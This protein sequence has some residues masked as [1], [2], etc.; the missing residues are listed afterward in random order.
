[1]VSSQTDISL[2]ARGASAPSTDLRRQPH[3]ELGAVMAPLHVGREDPTAADVGAGLEDRQREVD[4]GRALDRGA[5]GVAAELGPA[6]RPLEPQPLVQM[7]VVLVG[8]QDLGDVA[9]GPEAQ[10]DRAVADR[11]WQVR[12]GGHVRTGPYPVAPWSRSPTA[13]AA[14][15]ALVACG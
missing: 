8:D 4:P 3:P 1:M 12:K 11:L 6:R 9:L 15:S 2:S 10:R 13:S 14:P 5:L 7:P